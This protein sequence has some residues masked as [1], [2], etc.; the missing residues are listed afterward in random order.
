[1]GLILADQHSTIQQQPA[2]DPS[3]PPKNVNPDERAARAVNEALEGE[4]RFPEL[5]SYL[6]RMSSSVLSFT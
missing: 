6:S 2:A 3:R 4:A 5:D 1:M